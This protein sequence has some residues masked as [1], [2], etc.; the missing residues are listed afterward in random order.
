[1]K[2]LT[3]LVALIFIVGAM[4]AQQ[5]EVGETLKFIDSKSISVIADET[6]MPTDTLVP[7]GIANNSGLQIPGAGSEP[8]YVS[9]VNGYGDEAYAQQFPVTDAYYVE[10]FLIYFGAKEIVGAPDDLDAV[11]YDM[12]G[13]GTTSAG[14]NQTSPGSELAN[15]TINMDT[16]VD[17]TGFTAVSFTNPILVDNDYALGFDVSVLTDDTVAA[18]TSMNGD[19]LEEY[20]WVRWNDGSWNSLASAWNNFQVSLFI[21][22]VVDQSTMDINEQSFINGIKM[23]TY[24][25]PASDV[26][27]M[28]YQLENTADVTIKILDATGKLVQTE[29]LGQKEAGQHKATFS[30]S[31][32]DAG[33]YFYIME[34]GSNRLAKRMVIK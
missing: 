8:G 9:G 24:P 21:L 22:A 29:K 28:D 1:M 30:A 14:A 3:L 12:D 23:E 19:A 15:V 34:A 25:N 13:T 27:N 32:L 16:D 11:M 5:R 31:N 2:K 17:T 20:A 6:K 26:V 10:G 4:F 33:M 7:Y 18:V